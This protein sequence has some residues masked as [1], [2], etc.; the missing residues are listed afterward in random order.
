MRFCV[1]YRA[2]PFTP[3]RGYIVSGQ[4][5]QMVFHPRLKKAHKKTLPF[6]CTRVILSTK[7]FQRLMNKLFSGQIGKG[8]LFLDDV[9]V[10]TEDLETHLNV[11]GKVFGRALTNL[12]YSRKNWIF[13]DIEWD[14]GM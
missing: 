6:L 13:W 3:Y 9:A 14:M 11:L 8:L 10:Y 7:T 2:L 12:T 1:K 5:K 4:P